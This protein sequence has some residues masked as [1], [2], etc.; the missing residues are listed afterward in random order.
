MNT[1]YQF[2]AGPL[3]WI[4]FALF[5]GGSLYKVINLIL[6][7]QK[8]EAYLFCFLS[9]KWSL[10]SIL[11][12]LTPFGPRNMKLHPAMTVVTFIFHICLLLT[13]VFLLSHLILLEES[14]NISWWALPDQ[15]A[16][17]MTLL[18]IGACIFF[19]VR[20]INS[21]EVR[22]VTSAS[23]FVLLAIVAAPFVTGFWAYHQWAGY[24][25]AMILHIVTGE[26]MLVAIPFTRLSH[27]LFAVFT[28]AYIGSE[29]GGVR[30]AKDW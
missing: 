17:I 25:P 8:K 3:L 29:F 27:M 18:I 16:D 11:H 14:I 9:W 7:T 1:L 5:I 21:P 13:P 30:H 20:R 6:L 4:A 24:Q 15:V 12:W 2:V 10:R 28:R 26:I 23:D 22:Y 19:L